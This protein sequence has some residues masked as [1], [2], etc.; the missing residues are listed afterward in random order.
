MPAMKLRLPLAIGFVLAVGAFPGCVCSKSDEQPAPPQAMENPKPTHVG[1]AR[2]MLQ[3]SAR[4][5]RLAPIRAM[6]ML[7]AGAPRVAPE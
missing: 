6:Q 3:G 7:D 4:N 2:P 1:V 5:L